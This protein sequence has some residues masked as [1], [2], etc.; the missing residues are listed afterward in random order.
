MQYTP[1]IKWEDGLEHLKTT[2]ISKPYKILKNIIYRWQFK[3][4]YLFE[5]R[6]VA[7]AQSKRDKKR[8]KVDELWRGFED[9]P[10]W[11]KC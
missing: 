3:V 6:M 9:F 2:I 10:I 1:I 4:V 11:F 8:L 7:L 5:V